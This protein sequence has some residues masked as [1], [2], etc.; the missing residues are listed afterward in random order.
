LLLHGLGTT[1]DIAHGLYWLSKAADKGQGDAAYELGQ[2]IQ[3]DDEQVKSRY[4][5]GIMAGHAGCMRALA[6]LLLSEENDQ[7]F[8]PEDEEVYDGG[9]EIL[10]LLEMAADLKDTEAIYQLGL[11]YE[12]GL[13]TVI[14]NK[15]IEKALGYYIHAAERNHELAMIKAGEILGNILGLQAEAIQ[16]F[17]KAVNLANNIKAKVMLVSYDFQG[18]TSSLSTKQNH[19]ARNFEIL[20]DIIEEGFALMEK[21]STKLSSNSKR[22]QQIN[23]D[24]LGLAFYILG[25]CYELGRGTYVNLGLAKEWYHRSIVISQHVDAMYRLGLIYSTF[26]ENN[27]SALEWY[28]NATE[29]GRHRESHYQL[30][31]FHLHGLGGLEVNIIAAQKYFSKASDQG[32]PLATYELARIIWNHHCDYI[33]GYELFKLAAQLHVADASR[34]LGRLSHTGFL[35]H[36]IVIVQQDYKRAFAYYCE[37]AQMGDPISALMVGNYFEEGY[38]QEELGQDYERALQWYESAYRLNGG[39]LAELAIGKLKHTMSDAIADPKEAEDI[40]E[41]AF[42]WFE[43]AASDPINTIQG[44]YAKVMVALYHLNG[45]GRKPQ[46]AKTGFNMLLDIAEH[47]GREAFVSVARCYEQGV[48]IENNMKKAIDYWEMAA[49]MD[50]QG[51]LIRVGEIYEFGLSC[52]VDKEAAYSYYNRAEMIGISKIWIVGCG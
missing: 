27:V 36:G 6:L 11:A 51:A 20:R 25:Q 32:H 7:C 49:D 46:D 30:G 5:Q 40:R 21:E 38:L 43:S 4:E 24:G 50:D 31:L 9:A 39:G 41:E 48:G 3:D 33:Y 1:A 18:Y 14:S 37:A 28:R 19:D 47:G 2:F 13:G 15:D 8:A 42:V 10:K 44:V 17:Q 29:R 23:K 45:W 16:W 34:E 52:P 35:F 12:N 26:E 22:E